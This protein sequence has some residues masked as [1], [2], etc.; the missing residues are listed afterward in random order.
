MYIYSHFIQNACDPWILF[1]TLF[2][3]GHIA[4]VIVFDL[5]VSTHRE[6]FSEG[7]QTSVFCMMVSDLLSILS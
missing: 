1:V 7:S 2:L 4:S 6:W 5:L 3:N